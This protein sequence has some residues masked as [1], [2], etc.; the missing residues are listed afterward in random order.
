MQT[1]CCF[2]VRCLWCNMAGTK[3]VN[4]C[5]CIRLFTNFLYCGGRE[6][7]TASSERVLYIV[8][9]RLCNKPKHD[10]LSWQ[11]ISCRAMDSQNQACSNINPAMCC[12]FWLG[13]WGNIYGNRPQIETVLYHS[14]A[15]SL[16]F[17]SIILII[18]MLYHH[19]IILPHVYDLC[20]W[21]VKEYLSEPEQNCQH[22]VD[23][24]FKC[25]LYKKICNL[26]GI[27]LMFI[28]NGSI[29]NDLALVKVLV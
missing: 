21:H 14:C 26:I 24:I 15:L 12:P 19:I 22:F 25:A 7:A 8:N 5:I 27:L 4:I 13:W 16:L 3:V 17:H 9:W 18:S 6:M 28:P 23:D 11:F 2:R 20:M 10:C 29:N 1:I